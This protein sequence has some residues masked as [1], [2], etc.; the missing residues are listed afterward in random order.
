MDHRETIYF[1]LEVTAVKRL[2]IG[3][4]KLLI[5]CV[6]NARVLDLHTTQD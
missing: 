6:L 5:A 1:T 4:C 2:T 3:I